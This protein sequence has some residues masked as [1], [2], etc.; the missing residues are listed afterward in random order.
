MYTWNQWASIFVIYAVIGW[1]VEV[2]Y[3][4]VD[5]GRFVNR[6]FLN[7]PVCPIYGFGGCIVVECL[8]SFRGMGWLEF[9]GAFFLTSILEFI[10][11]YV[12]E[13]IFHEHWWDYSNKPFNI[14]GYVCLKFSILWGISCV[15]ILE[16]IQP[17]IEKFVYW[18]PDKLDKILVVIVAIFFLADL[19][20]TIASIIHWKRELRLTGE[21]VEILKSFSDGVGES[22]SSA[23]LRAID[24]RK[25]WKD[26]FEKEEMYLQIKEE[27]D[28]KK[29]DI[30][31]LKVKYTSLLK[32][33]SKRTR[34]LEKA[35]PRLL[36]IKP[37][38]YL[39]KKKDI[40]ENGE[41]DVK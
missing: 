20:F 15:F 35:F 34:R 19:I 1:C 21:I 37:S 9:I 18:I 40:K 29:Y 26:I 33:K 8:Y 16:T 41:D 4:A 27:L 11:G 23:V 12:L 25:E 32:G 30:E 13:K 17:A 3:A 6:G 31:Y 39:I 28:H 38:L 36:S 7:G 2:V 5:D 14:K 24:K 10:T 22:L